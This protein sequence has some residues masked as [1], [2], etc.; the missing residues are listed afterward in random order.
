MTGKGHG[1]PKVPRFHTTNKSLNLS[2]FRTEVHEFVGRMF[3][4]FLEEGKLL[5]RKSIVCFG[6]G[7]VFWGVV[8]MKL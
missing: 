7:S 3:E 5:K 8:G 6:A 1:W 2:P 4:E